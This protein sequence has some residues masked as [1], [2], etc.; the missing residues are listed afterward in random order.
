[1]TKDDLKIIRNY[2]DAL[3]KFS[4]L[5]HTTYEQ[6]KDG[7]RKFPSIIALRIAEYLDEETEVFDIILDHEKW[8]D[9][10]EKKWCLVYE[11]W[12]KTGWFKKAYVERHKILVAHKYNSAV[13]AFWAW[14]TENNMHNVLLKDVFEEYKKRGDE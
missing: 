11:I 3:K 8:G 12:E 2:A 7:N 14:V 9:K 4:I 10:T 1:M 5:S 6:L 13:K